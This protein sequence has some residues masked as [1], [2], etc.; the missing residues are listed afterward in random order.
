MHLVNVKKAKYDTDYRIFLSFD[1][2]LSGVVDLKS[3]LFERDA[4]AFERLKDVGQ[5]KKFSV[6]FHTVTWGND[7]DLAPEY[8]HYLLIKQHGRKKLENDKK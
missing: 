2:G 1:D 8:L 3:L 5:F 7:L 6:K 4:P